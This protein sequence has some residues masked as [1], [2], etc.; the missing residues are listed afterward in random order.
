MSTI[1]LEIVSPERLILSDNRVSSVVLPGMSGSMGI[2]PHHA[3]LITSL[4]AGVLEWTIEG[5]KSSLAIEGGFAEVVD[6]RLIVLVT[7][8][9]GGDKE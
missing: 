1:S 9:S 4:K 3:P 7:L 8:P 5:E 6:N 2:L